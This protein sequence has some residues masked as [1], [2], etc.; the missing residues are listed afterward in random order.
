[1]LPRTVT[2]ERTTLQ[3]HCSDSRRNRTGKCASC[4]SLR[5]KLTEFSSSEGPGSARFVNF[6][7]THSCPGWCSHSIRMIACTPTL[8]KTSKIRRNEHTPCEHQSESGRKYFLFVRSYKISANT[9]FS[10][11]MRNVIHMDQSH[12]FF[13]FF[14]AQ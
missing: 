6:V 5:D 13:W 8:T 1:M 2:T 10:H 7:L 3:C 9:N 4:I 14:F 11:S 12:V